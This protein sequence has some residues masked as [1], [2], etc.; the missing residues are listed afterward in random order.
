MYCKN[1]LIFSS[2]IGAAHGLSAIL[3]MLLSFPSYLDRNPDAEQIVKNSVDFFLSL[4]TASG[5][6]PAA[7]DD[8]ADDSNELVH[9]CHG[10]PG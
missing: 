4:Q 8:V 2:Y 7:M 3:Q 6:F 10:A 9:W 5:N 1:N